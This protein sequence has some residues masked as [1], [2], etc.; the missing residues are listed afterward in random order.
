MAN[1]CADSCICG[2]DYRLRHRS[3]RSEC[4][5]DGILKRGRFLL[6]TRRRRWISDCLLHLCFPTTPDICLRDT[7]LKPVV[8]WTP[9]RCGSFDCVQLTFRSGALFA[10]ELKNGATVTSVFTVGNMITPGFGTVVM[11]ISSIALVTVMSVNTYGA[12]LV[13]LTAIDGFRPIHLIRA[14]ACHRCT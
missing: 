5:E 2:A 7:K 9:R 13:T 11:L 10:I 14:H 3:R 6:A 4:L 1:V 12:I 8:L